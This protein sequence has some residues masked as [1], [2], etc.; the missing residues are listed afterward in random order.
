M[1][2]RRLLL[3]AGLTRLSIFFPPAAGLRSSSSRMARLRAAR[4]ARSIRG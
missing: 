2:Y 4:A 3:D 1:E